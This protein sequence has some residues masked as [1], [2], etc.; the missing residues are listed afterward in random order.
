MGAIFLSVPIDATPTCP[1]DLSKSPVGS[2]SQSLLGISIEFCG[3]LKSQK[4]SFLIP[5][6]HSLYRS[7][8]LQDAYLAYS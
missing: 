5:G 4:V 3:L 2:K 1:K 8:G 6:S 7:L